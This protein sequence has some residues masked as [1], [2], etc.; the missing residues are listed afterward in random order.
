VIGIAKLSPWSN[1]IR[2]R[3]FS[4]IRVPVGYARAASVTPARSRF[5]ASIISCSSKGLTR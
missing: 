3:V 5:N 1:N 2:N 4:S